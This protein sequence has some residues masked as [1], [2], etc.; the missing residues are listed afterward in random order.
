MVTFNKRDEV[1]ITL[2]IHFK[3]DSTVGRPLSQPA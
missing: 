2:D 3:D 1:G